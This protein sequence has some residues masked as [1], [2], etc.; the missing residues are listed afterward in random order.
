[1]AFITRDT[2]ICTHADIITFFYIMTT[3]VEALVMVGN[4]CLEALFR[5]SGQAGAC[6]KAIT[7]TISSFTNHCPD[8]CCSRGSKV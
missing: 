6:N 2:T 5:D 3:H 7:T 1:M 4:R 8:K